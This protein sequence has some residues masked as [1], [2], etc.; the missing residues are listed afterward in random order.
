MWRRRQQGSAPSGDRATFL[1][2]AQQLKDA[3][4]KGPAA[5]KDVILD[6][7]VEA[8][9]IMLPST[10]ISSDVSIADRKFEPRVVLAVSSRARHL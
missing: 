3:A 8:N 9:G 10:S 5:S 2:A 7:L 1:G 6:A 4:Q